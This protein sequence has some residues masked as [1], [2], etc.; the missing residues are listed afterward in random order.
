MVFSAL[1][2]NIAIRRK[3]CVYLR[4]VRNYKMTVRLLI[5]FFLL[6]PF[7]IFGQTSM[8]NSNNDLSK[9]IYSI[10]KTIIKN[11]KI[12][13]NNGLSIT[14]ELNCNINQVDTVYLQ[15][16]LIK[17]KLVDTTHKSNP[18]DFAVA[19]NMT[20]PDK[21]ILTPADIEYIL[22]EKQIFANFKWDNKQ[23][24]FNLENKKKYY[25][26][27]VPYFN[28]THD[29]VI[30]MYKYHCSGLC[31]GGSTILLTKTEKGWDSTTLELWFH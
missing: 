9:D 1:F 27:S 7:A 18:S 12:N 4:V 21:N 24:G 31:G 13:T 20:Y 14:P 25:T 30:V 15:T 26:F 10:I 22:K 3:T 28:L 29:K 17:P 11:E 8:G 2:A 5:L 6:T 19:S 23:L 16:L